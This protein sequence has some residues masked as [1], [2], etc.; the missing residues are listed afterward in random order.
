[1]SAKP[2]ATARIAISQGFDVTRELSEDRR[3]KH[4]E[5][6]RA[7]TFVQSCSLNHGIRN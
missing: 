1:M 3:G 7:G 2:L 5:P 4:L 6:I